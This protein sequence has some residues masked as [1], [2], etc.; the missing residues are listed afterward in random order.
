MLKQSHLYTFI[1]PGKKFALYFLEGQKLIHDLV[2]THGLQQDSFAYFRSTVLSIQL[3][4]GLL[5]HGEYFCYYIDSESPYFRLKIE[6]NT[7]GLMRGMIY[8]DNLGPASDKISGQVR[9]VKFHPNAEMP[10]QSTISLTDVG[11]NEILNQVLSK[12]YQVKSR[13][14]V[15]EK[16][17]Q[18]FMLH[19]LP[20]SSN[21]EPS[22]LNEAFSNYITPIKEIMSKGITD[23]LSI[24]KAFKKIK[25]KFLA[26]QP[27]EFK[28]GCSK[29]QMIDNVKKYANSGDDDLFT[30][31]KKDIEVICEY[32][33]TKY[34]ITERDIRETSTD[35]H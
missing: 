6:M 24:I 18:S 32:C 3:I 8:A 33:K 23:Q 13:V 30:P 29:K 20:L 25:F 16:S 2:L 21:E 31:D 14:F 1:D 11:I 10:Y 34:R 15:S 17:D 4:M 26:R 5:K 22:D 12:S 27:V 35:Y 28:C 9:L 19:Q 7:L